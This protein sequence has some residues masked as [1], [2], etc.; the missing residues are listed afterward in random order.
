MSADA[1]GKV[2]HYYDKI[3]VAIVKLDKEVSV[4]QALRFGDPDSGV[5]QTVE[6]MQV[7]H[8]PVEKAKKGDEVGIKVTGKVKDKTLVFRA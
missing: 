5:V 1:V 6:S 4:G 3:G 8:A 2:T 7:D